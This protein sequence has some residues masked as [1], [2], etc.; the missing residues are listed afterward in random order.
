MIKTGQEQL[1]FFGTMI[2]AAHAL[3]L[4]VTAEG[5][6]TPAQARYLM[7][8]GCDSLQGYL[9]AKPPRPASWPGRW[10]ARSRRST[11]S[12][13]GAKSADAPADP[14]GRRYAR[15]SS[16]SRSAPAISALRSHSSRASSAS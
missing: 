11:R 7:E 2:N 15:R 4:K 6:E 13:P 14:A 10:R 5:I 12:T 9:F 8:R 16:S 3:G 1:P